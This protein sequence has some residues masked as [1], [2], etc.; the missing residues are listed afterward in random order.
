[1]GSRVFRLPETKRRDSVVAP[2]HYLTCIAG[3]ANVFDVMPAG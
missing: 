3:L 1:M 2:S